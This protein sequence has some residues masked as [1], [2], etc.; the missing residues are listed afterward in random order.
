MVTENMKMLSEEYQALLITRL[1]ALGFTNKKLKRMS[2][3]KLEDLYAQEIGNKVKTAYKVYCKFCGFE[4]TG[5]R[6]ACSKC[7]KCGRM[8]A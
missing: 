2:W 3:Q 1:Q 6:Y 5:K 8:V 4:F 7:L